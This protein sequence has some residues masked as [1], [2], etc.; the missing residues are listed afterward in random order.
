MICANISGTLRKALK[1]R[2][3]ISYPHVTVVCGKPEYTDA[4]KDTISDPKVITE[5]L[6]PSTRN[7]YQ[8]NR[9][10]LYRQLHSLR[11]FLIVERYRR[12]ADGSWEILAYTGEN[13]VIHLN[14]VKASLTVAERLSCVD[15]L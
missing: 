10:R 3:L 5:P 12:L 15:A 8:A 4:R 6:S 1:D 14:S 2:A 7:F 9:R 11:E 13:A